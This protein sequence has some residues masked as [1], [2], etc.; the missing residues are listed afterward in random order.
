MPVL[1]QASRDGE[2]DDVV[3]F[4]GAELTASVAAPFVGLHH[5]PIDPLLPAARAHPVA[6][7]LLR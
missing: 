1:G 7:T 4:I 6:A 3:D 2:R 5:S